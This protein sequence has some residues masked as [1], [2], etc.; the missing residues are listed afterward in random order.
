M[1]DIVLSKQPELVNNVMSF[2]LM[3][4]H[5][6]VRVITNWDVAISEDK[7]KNSKKNSYKSFRKRLLKFNCKA[8][9]NN[10]PVIVGYN[11]I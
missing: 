3:L 9:F 6:N 11:R 1:L 5:F 10:K 8:V 4:V 2:S 7:R